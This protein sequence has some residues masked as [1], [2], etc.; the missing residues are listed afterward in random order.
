MVKR[1]KSL[2]AESK[3]AQS[4]RKAKAKAKPL[5]AYFARGTNFDGRQVPPPKPKRLRARKK[6]QPPITKSTWEE[7]TDLTER[8]VQSGAVSNFKPQ[9]WSMSQ[10]P[11]LPSIVFSEGTLTQDIS[12]G[13]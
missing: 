12:L 13:H 3:S 11:T 2:A 1:N 6:K 9:P 10:T 5:V 8:T 7:S 4:M